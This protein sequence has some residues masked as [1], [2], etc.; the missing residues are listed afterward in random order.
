MSEQDRDD[1]VNRRKVLECMTWVGTGVLWSIAG[2]VPRSLGII[3]EA[4]AAETSGL[5]FVQISDSHI[6]FDFKTPYPNAVG[7]LQECIGRVKAL[8]KKPAFMI[9]TGDISHLSKASQFDD[10]D[11]AIAEA[12]LDVHYVPGEH[13]FV[14]AEQ[15]L[16]MDRYGKGTKGFGWYSFDANGV[17]FVGLV[18][19]H[20]LKAGGMGNLG[21]DQLEWL[22]ADLK[23]RSA[24]TPIV[25]FAHIPLW[26]VYPN[27]G[28]GTERRRAGAVLPQALRL[29]HRAQ[30]AHPSG[31]A[32][33][34]GQRHFPHRPLH[35]LPAAG[36]GH[37]AVAG[38]D[39]GPRRQAAQHARHRRRHLQTKQ[40]TVGDH[41]FAAAKLNG[42]RQ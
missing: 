5:T 31:H 39:E 25:V 37:G 23:G 19:V 21:N 6:G 18:N 4:V 7:T 33:G 30:R 12:K 35:R 3:D 32:E 11:K 1:G 17:H 36:S 26:T 42:A 8:P 28:W 34:R 13:D 27:W 10:A 15:K 41:R 38:A 2:G 16:F 20:D 22:E 29:R 24:S 40:Q 14:D 9:H